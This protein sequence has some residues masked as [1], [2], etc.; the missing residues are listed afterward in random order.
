MYVY[1]RI[2]LNLRKDYSPFCEE[3]PIVKKSAIVFLQF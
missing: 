3:I 2:Y 1:V